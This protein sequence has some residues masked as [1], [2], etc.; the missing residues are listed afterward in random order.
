[1]HPVSATLENNALAA[2]IL[3]PRNAFIRLSMLMTY[4]AINAWGCVRM[5]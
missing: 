1:M 2:N 3:I 5:T 4:A